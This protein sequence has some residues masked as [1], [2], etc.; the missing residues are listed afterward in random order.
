MVLPGNTLW[1]NF[2]ISDNVIL[3]YNLRVCLHALHVKDTVLR[4]GDVLRC[5]NRYGP[6]C[7]KQTYFGFFPLK[8]RL[9]MS[10]ATSFNDFFVT[11]FIHCICRAGVSMSWDR[12]MSLTTKG[13]LSGLSIIIINIFK[14]VRVIIIRKTLT[15]SR[16]Q[17]DT[18]H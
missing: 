11:H 9:V 12:S 6:S 4:L 17:V 8:E 2:M 10:N 1:V 16:S 18:V 14:I 5:E 7:T 3:V 13:S 15:L